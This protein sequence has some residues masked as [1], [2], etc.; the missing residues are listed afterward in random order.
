M[1][2]LITLPPEIQQSI[3]A[4][5]NFPTLVRF[6]LTCK[7]F[8]DLPTRQ[9]IKL[10]LFDLESNFISGC[11]KTPRDEPRNTHEEQL[12]DNLSLMGYSWQ[13]T[14]LFLRMAPC[15][16]CLN[17]VDRSCIPYKDT[18]GS[19]NHIS[20]GDLE[21]HLDPS[22]G[23]PESLLPAQPQLERLCVDCLLQE[24]FPDVKTRWIRMQLKSVVLCTTCDTHQVVNNPINNRQLWAAKCHTCW[25][26]EQERWVNFKQN[27]ETIRD[28]A[29]MHHVWMEMIDQCAP[30]WD[31]K[32]TLG[33]VPSFSFMETPAWTYTQ[34]N[35]FKHEEADYLESEQEVTGYIG[36]YPVIRPKA[37]EQFYHDEEEEL[38]DNE[39]GW[40]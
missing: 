8:R 10:A 32:T 9:N 5:L 19:S 22:N 40:P 34:F 20:L 15:Y 31:M 11:G 25:G 38:E 7:Y 18:N 27:L 6:R 26:P 24:G 30:A 33:P 37:S 16:G 14:T 21:L 17:L 29:G 3:V 1:P 39:T 13:D 35:D 28:E 2:N 4:K 23:R 12:I 36:A